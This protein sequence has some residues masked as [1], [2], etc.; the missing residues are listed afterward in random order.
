MP[1]PPLL[2]QIP[3]TYPASLVWNITRTLFLFCSQ[4]SSSRSGSFS[5]AGP[6]QVAWLIAERRA[7]TG[8]QM[9]NERKHDAYPKGDDR[10][11]ARAASAVAVIKPAQAGQPYWPHRGM[12]G[13][14][15][16][17][18]FYWNV[19]SGCT[20]RRM[21]TSG[22][23]SQ[24]SSSLVAQQAA[25]LA[26]DSVTACQFDPPIARAAIRAN[27]VGFLHGT[28]MSLTRFD[29]HIAMR[30]QSNDRAEMILRRE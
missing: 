28:N 7:V 10:S 22:A 25:E 27:D 11:S 23:P 14:G 29:L 1:V 18:S 5:I 24:T 8:Q 6:K 2:P 21:A 9:Q 19:F 4:E 16:F 15:A 20:V 3:S 13:H 30:S 17:T 12:A 26:F